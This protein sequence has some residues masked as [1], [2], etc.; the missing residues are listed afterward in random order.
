[1]ILYIKYA[2][3]S[4][5]NQCRDNARAPKIV[6]GERQIECTSSEQCEQ[7][8]PVPRNI[9]YV[10]MSV[11]KHVCACHPSLPSRTRC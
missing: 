6:L 1:M 10:G 5:S 7:H 4:N 3:K 9:V 8:E 2:G 11:V